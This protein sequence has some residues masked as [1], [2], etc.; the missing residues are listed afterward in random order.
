MTVLAGLDFGTSSVKLVVAHPDGTVLARAQAAYPTQAG[1]DGAAEQR[2]GDWWEAAAEAIAESGLGARIDAVGLTGQM[3]DLIPVAAGAALRPVML[4][5][6]TRATAQHERLRA[7]LA[8]WERLSGNQQDA[9]NVAAK[10]AWLA[11]HEPETLAAAEQL[12]LGAPG[13][14]GWRA[15]GVAACD[16]VTASTTGLLDVHARG[17]SPEVARAA[18]ARAEQLPRLVGV[19]AGDARLGP[20]HAE[21]AAELGL[22][23]GIPVVHALGDAGSA[24]DGLVGSE[25]GDAYLYLGTTGWLA[26]VTEAEPAAEASPIHSLVLPGWEARLRIGAVQAA[27]SAADWSRR[28][29][30]PGLD[31]AAVEALAAPRLDEPGALA[32]RPLALPGL[33]GERTPVRDPE[34]RGAFV[35]VREGTQAVDFHLAVLTGVALGLRH[36]ADELGI[37]QRRI[38]LIGGASASPAWRRILADV[39][40]ATVVTREAEDPGSHSALRAVAA[41]LGIPN[42]LAPRFAAGPEDVETAPSEART[43]YARLVGIHRALYDGLAPTFHRLARVE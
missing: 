22:R 10:I 31:F 1:P 16:L 36:V 2:A 27:G 37:R 40:D 34:F 26:A 18:G 7:A 30:L 13:Y 41:A 39:F 33:A 23:P 15:T 17:W 19:T 6:D 12:L 5:S 43:G 8:D 20:L 9:S 42:S 28:T 32:V 25:P 35:G 11:E 38:P 4:Y 29:F 24:T 14:V 3:Q 21:A